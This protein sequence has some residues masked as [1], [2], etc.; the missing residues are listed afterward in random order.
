[1]K[2]QLVAGKKAY[3]YLTIISMNFILSMCM[4]NDIKIHTR[5]NYGVITGSRFSSGYISGAGSSGKGAESYCS[6]AGDFLAFFYIK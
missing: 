5:R 3:S 6:P 2:K 1:M 4:Q